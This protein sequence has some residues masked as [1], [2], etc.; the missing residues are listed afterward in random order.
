MGECHVFGV[1]SDECLN[2]ALE[3]RKEWEVKGQA[4]VQQ[5]IRK[6]KQEDSPKLATI[7]RR[8]SVFLPPHKLMKKPTLSS[9]DRILEMEVV[10]STVEKKVNGSIGLIE[11]KNSNSDSSVSPTDDDGSIFSA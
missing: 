10:G 1:A 3:N 11:Q 4:I 5:M 7:G 9:E 6:V 2:Y 8:E